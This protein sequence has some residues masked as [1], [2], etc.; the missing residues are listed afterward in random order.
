MAVNTKDLFSESFY[1]SEYPDV[2][3]AVEGGLF[4][5]GYEH[6][7]EFGR[8]EHRQPSAYFDESYYLQ[9]YPDVAQAVQNGE[10]K[11]GLAHF[12]LEGQY[13]EESRSP[14][15]LVDIQ[16]LDAYA[17]KENPQAASEIAKDKITG[18]EYLVESPLDNQNQFLSLWVINELWTK[19]NFNL[20]DAVASDAI[21]HSSLGT[22]K[23]TETFKGIVSAFRAA[24]PDLKVSIEA[25]T[26]TSEWA[27]HRF[28]LDGHHTGAPLF[29]V[30]PSGKEIT[31]TGIGMFKF[32]GYGHSIDFWSESDQLGLLQQLGLG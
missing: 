24:I 18:I 19:G 27:V 9:R 3:A 13:V 28:I 20:L 6:F 14:S 17:A 32:D 25:E 12:L 1:L 22:E 29:G 31:L 15:L 30:P 8:K 23:G 21:F 5:N 10:F 7:K 16:A 2:R 4:H 11:D 26:Y